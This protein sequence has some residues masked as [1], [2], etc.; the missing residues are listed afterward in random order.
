M[1]RQP[2][3]VA[4]LPALVT[5]QRT[6]TVSPASATAGATTAEGTRLGFRMRIVPV[7]V[8]RLLSLL[9]SVNTPP[10]SVTTTT[11]RAPERSAGTAKAAE[12]AMDAP[13][14][15][16]PPDGLEASLRN[17]PTSRAPS[18]PV[19]GERYTSSRHATPT[20]ALPTLEIDHET[21]RGWPASAAAGTSP[22]AATRSG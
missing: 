22:T 20:G 19:P 17:D 7:L 8:A 10:A 3:K 1:A 9:G 12:L 5:V 16:A 21:V 18:R 6:S 15:S 11:R 13:A 14:A 4:P 2:E